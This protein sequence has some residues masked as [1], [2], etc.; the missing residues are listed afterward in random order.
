VSED[1]T[2]RIYTFESSHLKKDP[3]PDKWEQA[4][5]G[6]PPPDVQVSSFATWDEVAAWYGSL[7]R[8]SLEVTPEIRAKAEELTRGKKCGDGEDSRHLRSRFHQIS[9]Y[10]HLPWTGSLCTAC[11]L[12]S[13]G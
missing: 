12:G 5:S 9:V 2:R 1:G 3:D 4:L 7:Q 11:R 6:D 8:P 10:Q 13:L